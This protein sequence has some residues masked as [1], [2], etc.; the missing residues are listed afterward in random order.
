MPRRPGDRR[1]ALDAEAA[2][3]IAIKALA[4]IAADPVLLPRFL[5]LTGLDPASLRRAA[6]ED[7]FLPGV[8]DFILGHEPTLAAFCEAEGLP[9]HQVPAARM[10][11][12]PVDEVSE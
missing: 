10:A 2:Q 9:L 7:G 1:N 4:F 12:H 8:L 6:Q 11:L 3:A 5:G